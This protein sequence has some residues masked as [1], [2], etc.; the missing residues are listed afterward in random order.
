MASNQGLTPKDY[1]WIN[2]KCR[3]IA[4]MEKHGF[5]ERDLRNELYVLGVFA[6]RHFHN[7]GMPTDLLHPSLNDQTAS[8]EMVASN[9]T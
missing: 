9:Q 1:N 4:A 6:F 2:N 7:A 5:S 8:L 3:S